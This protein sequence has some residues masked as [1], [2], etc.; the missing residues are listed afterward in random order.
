MTSKAR[1]I[2]D[3]LDSNGDV[4]VDAL[5]TQPQLGRRNLIIN[6]DFQVDQRGAS[7]TSAA[8]GYRL[9]RWLHAYSMSVTQSEG[10]A[11]FTDASG[12]D[13]TRIQQPMENMRRVLKGRTV[14]LSFKA[15]RV[16]G[17]ASMNARIAYTSNGYRDWSAGNIN[18]T[19][20][21][22]TF[23]GQFTFT[24][25]EVTYI[26][27]VLLLYIGQNNSIEIAEVQLELGSVATPFEHRS[28][29]EEL[30]LCQR[31]YQKQS[32]PQV[33]YPTDAGQITWNVMLSVP[34]RAAPSISAESAFYAHR[35]DAA[36]IV[37]LWDGAG[38]YS[39][40]S[41]D[42]EQGEVLIRNNYDGAVANG[43]YTI[44]ASSTSGNSN[45]NLAKLFFDAEL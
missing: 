3:L 41:Y 1:N 7:G 43:I 14:T 21:W 35:K 44:N 11:T 12:N 18:P 20:E 32:I 33:V 39:A 9:D 23:S 10:Y 4:Q 37:T 2:A 6:G 26:N 42:Y 28:Y 13:S 29:G 22:Q 8:T 40:S 30:A 17:S 31:Y 45:S 27:P 16:S 34:L 25:S 15:R 24:D 36:G 19:S 5:D 38:A